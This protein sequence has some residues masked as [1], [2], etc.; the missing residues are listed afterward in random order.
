MS[1]A[2][3]RALDFA[4]VRHA[5]QRRKGEGGA[6]YV[7]HL[8]EVAMLLAEVG[9]VEDEEILVAAV[10]HDVVEDTPT[11]IDEVGDR[12]GERVK[13]I[14]RSVTD[15][16]SLPRTER[17]RLVLEHLVHA[18]VSTKLVKLAD[19][20]SNMNMPPAE[21]SRERLLAYVEWSSE[22]ARLCAGVCAALDELYRERLTRVRASL[23]T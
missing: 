13:H 23:G 11:S 1:R 17:R 14:V 7:N 10:L 4:A 8:I 5:D 20:S 16:K 6:P 12:F 15:D 2:V 22:A 18:D 21:W 19:L 9:G 3:L